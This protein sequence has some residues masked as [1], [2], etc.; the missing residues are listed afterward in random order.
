MS[1][2]TSKHPP[3]LR[4]PQAQVVKEAYA[5]LK[6][7]SAPNRRLL[8]AAAT[9]FGKT[10]LGSTFA[11]DATRK[12]W[13]VFFIVDRDK[14][15]EQSLATFRE[16]LSVP[17]G[18]L[19]AGY[20]EDR[21][22][23]VQIASRQTMQSRGWWREWIR[24]GPCIIMPDECHETSFAKVVRDEQEFPR[25]NQIWIGLTATP[26]RLS[27][28][29]GLGDLFDDMVQS[30]PPKEL[31]AQGYLLW[32]RYVVVP[33]R[34]DHGKVGLVGGDYN[35]GNLAKVYNTPRAIASLWR[36]WADHVKGD[37][38]VIFA[39]DKDHAKAIA[40][41]WG[42]QGAAASI[43][44]EESDEAE[45]AKAYAGLKSGR[46]PTLVNVNVATKGFDET[47]LRWVVLARATKSVSL[48]HQMIGRGGRTDRP[49]F[50][51]GKE[52]PL[53]FPV[54]CRGCRA[55]QPPKHVASWPTWFGVLDQ[56]GTLLDPDVCLPDMFDRYELHRGTGGAPGR[57]P[58]KTCQQCGHIVPIS[59]P[60][61]PTDRGGCGWIFPVRRQQEQVG[62]ARELAAL[63]K[64]RRDYSYKARSR[65]AQKHDPDATD[66][67]WYTGSTP[68]PELTPEIRLHAVFPRPTEK[69]RKDWRAHLEQC[70]VKKAARRAKEG[71]VFD[72]KAWVEKWM[73][74]EFGE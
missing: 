3:I 28:R 16:H 30:P 72:E 23:P 68:R 35:R 71:L 39:V 54:V 62:K 42:T 17:I 36:N 19:K 13:R 57:P 50:Q 10:V 73:R 45:R 41:H 64:V 18:V 29:E 46:I 25:T 38:N 44:T 33:D 56:T 4:P 63:D 51:C 9:G 37:R 59:I 40:A 5:K 65:W 66:R 26:W 20:T 15:V 55:E 34:V 43:I 7:L 11:H 12:G 53:A 6:A 32:P 47:K 8:V 48:L 67:A 24:Q 31:M 58:T 70:A 14:L 21:L 60:V 22:A 27:A 74:W 69:D 49:C 2:P 1:E 52:V 61:C